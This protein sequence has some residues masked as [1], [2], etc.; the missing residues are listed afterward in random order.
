[1]KPPQSFA[2]IVCIAVLVAF[3]GQCSSTGPYKAQPLSV[4][5]P[6][7]AARIDGPGFVILA[8]RLADEGAAVRVLGERSRK[9][10]SVA[11]IVQVS[12]ASTKAF[13]RLSADSLALRLPSGELLPPLSPHQVLAAVSVPLDYWERPERLRPAP[14]PLPGNAKVDGS[15][16][17]WEVGG[18]GAFVLL[19]IAGLSSESAKSDARWYKKGASAD[20][21]EKTTATRTV[22]P[23]KKAN[24]LVVFLPPEGKVHDDT[25]FDVV[26]DL[27]VD[28]KPWRKTVT[29]P[30]LP[31]HD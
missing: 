16:P 5:T 21:V 25:P 11:N 30:A 28:G 14:T 27:R 8:G 6:P 22:G 26:F 1:M 19:G 20:V 18:V 13:L 23:G 10:A 4:F 17:S 7:R 9:L 24:F 2:K 15:G 31:S 12:V 3:V 29:V